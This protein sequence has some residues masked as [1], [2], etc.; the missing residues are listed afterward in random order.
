MEIF[1]IGY[2]DEDNEGKYL[3]I[4]PEY[5]VGL[6]RLNMVSHMF[7]LWW[8]H[9][10]DS[11]ENRKAK[12]S[13]PRVK[14]PPEP[15]QEMGTFAT[16]SPRRPNPIGLTLVKIN[17]IMGCRIRIDHIDAFAGTPIIDLKPYL[18]SGDRVDE[19]ISLPPWF[20]H[21]RESRPFNL[22]EKSS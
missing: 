1:P 10:N 11:K 14:N 21:L 6:Y 3:D 17:E 8:I 12:K 13:I 9:Q 2:V 5:E 7:V 19:N 22:Q 15:P 20:G 16:R 4:L 18:P